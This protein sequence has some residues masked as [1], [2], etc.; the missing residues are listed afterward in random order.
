MMGDGKDI[1]GPF[2]GHQGMWRPDIL[3]EDSGNGESAFRICEING[4]F[5]FNGT[6]W[7]GYWYDAQ[8]RRMLADAALHAQLDGEVRIH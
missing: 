1:V 2:E 6:I 4:R 3:I 5:P 7:V 8:R